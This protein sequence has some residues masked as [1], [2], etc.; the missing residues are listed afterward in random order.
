MASGLGELLLEQLCHTIE[1]L[2][3]LSVAQETGSAA[4]QMEPL[5]LVGTDSLNLGIV[6]LLLKFRGVNN[7]RFEAAHW[8]HWGWTAADGS[9][10]KSDVDATIEDRVKSIHCGG[11]RGSAE[12]PTDLGIMVIF[13]GCRRHV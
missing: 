13:G 1:Q 5:H 8:A 12:H 6:Q 10:V 2:G 4:I 9:S 3:A 7:A 11:C